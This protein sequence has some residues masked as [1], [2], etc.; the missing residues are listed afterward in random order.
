MAKPVVDIAYLRQVLDYETE[1]GLFMWKVSVSNNVKVG[2][3]AGSKTKKGY[4]EIGLRGKQY[5][6]HLLAWL[7]HYGAYPNLALDHIN[8][9]KTDNRISNLREVTH[10]ENSHNRSDMKNNSSG[11]PGVFW[12]GERNCWIAVIWNNRKRKVLGSFS[13]PEKASEAY[14]SA[15]AQFLPCLT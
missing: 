13:D 5:R 3:I 4:L 14:K 6:A 10:T 1:T 11:Y 9:I 15:K 2:D 8:R 7:Y 12:R